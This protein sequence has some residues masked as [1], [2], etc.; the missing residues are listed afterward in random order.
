MI[1]WNTF[2][3]FLSVIRFRLYVFRKWKISFI[4]F[5]VPQIYDGE[6]R[7]CV[8]TFHLYVFQNSQM[9]FF[10]AKMLIKIFRLIYVPY[11]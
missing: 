10:E 5:F 1:L 4:R 3:T 11:R 2:Y 7:K 8:F 6:K 9:P